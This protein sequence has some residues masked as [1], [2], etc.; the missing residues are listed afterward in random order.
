MIRCRPFRRWREGGGTD[1]HA[2]L[3][4]FRETELDYEEIVTTVLP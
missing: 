1:G 2:F 4:A 3:Q